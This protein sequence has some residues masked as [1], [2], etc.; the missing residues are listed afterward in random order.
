MDLW[1]FFVG[2]IL[3]EFSLCARALEN[4]LLHSTQTPTRTPN[5]QRHC[6]VENRGCISICVWVHAFMC[7]CGCLTRSC[8][9]SRPCL[10]PLQAV[11]DWQFKSNLQHTQEDQILVAVPEFLTLI[12]QEG[13]L[14]ALF[15]DG[16]T[17]RLPTAQIA[18]L[19]HHLVY[20]AEG[21]SLI[22][23]F[24]PEQP[25]PTSTPGFRSKADLARVAGLVCDAALARGSTDNMSMVLAQFQGHFQPELAARCWPGFKPLPSRPGQDDEG[26]YPVRFVEVIPPQT[27]GQLQ[28]QA[29]H[30]GHQQQPDVIGRSYR[31]IHS[32]RFFVFRPCSHPP[33]GLRHCEC[34]FAAFGVFAAANV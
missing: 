15:C 16:I 2:V 19:L 14:L 17:E 6:K 12:A 23:P 11:G 5:I 29:A 27:G 1:L 8:S 3:L 21:I 25:Q 18:G 32:N 7:S 24:D 30:D 28:G 9:D 10:H 33:N 22:E 26:L 20:E 13:D 4:Q 31:V 34:P